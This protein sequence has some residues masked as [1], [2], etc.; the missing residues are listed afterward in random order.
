MRS[1]KIRHKRIGK[2]VYLHEEDVHI[3]KNGGLQEDYI[4]IDAEGKV[5]PTNPENEQFTR[6][7]VVVDYKQLFEDAQGAIERKDT[8]IQELSYRIGQAES[9]L[10]NSIS[11]I[12]YKK[13]TLLLESAKKHSEEEKHDLEKK[14]EKLQ[15]RLHKW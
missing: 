7:P 10:K 11:M 4:V 1:G 14:I 6:R 2:K 5:V 15:R 3:I 8:L 13:A 12:E 9:E